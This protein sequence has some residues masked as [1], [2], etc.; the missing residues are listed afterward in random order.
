MAGARTD[1]RSFRLQLGLLFLFMALVLGAAIFGFMGYQQQQI[2]K[3][4]LKSQADV[5]A[6]LAAQDIARLVYLDEPDMASDIT[7]RLANIPEIH[8]AVFYDPRG[9][10]LLR[11]P[12]RGP[13]PRHAITLDVPVELNGMH[14]GHAR[15]TFF[16]PRLAAQQR[17]AQNLFFGFVGAVLLA[18]LLFA[19]YLDRAFVARLSRLSRAL[20]RA[21]SRGDFKQR[22]RPDR[23]DEIGQAQAHFDALL[24]LVETQTRELQ[25]QASHDGLTGLYNRNHLLQ[26]LERLLDVP[27]LKGFH[28]VCYLD[29]DRFKVVNDTC[30]HAAGDQLL[31]ELARLLLE[32]LRKEPGTLIGRLGGDE[33]LILVRDRPAQEIARLMNRVLRAIGHYE[34]RYLEREFPIGV[35]IGCILLREERGTP[36]EVISAADGACYQAK[37]QR[38][39]GIVTHRLDAPE[40]RAHQVRMDWVS[41]INTA[42]EARAFRLYLQPIVDAG[43]A[44][45]QLHYEALLRL[46]EAGQ[47]VIGPDQFIPVAERFGLSP[48]ID[49]WVMERLFEILYDNP[50]FLRRVGRIS[51]NLS[52]LT[53]ADP[54]NR[55]AIDRLFKAFPLAP[56]KLCFEIT[57]TAIISEM[58]QARRFMRHFRGRGVRFAMDDFGTGMASF[59]Y[60]KDLDF[61]ILKIDGSF[62]RPIVRDEVLRELTRAM[63]RIGRITGKE[64]V[65]EQVEDEPTAD[66]LRA[67]GVDYLQGWLFARARPIEAVIDE[68]CRSV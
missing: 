39:G 46:H 37:R 5:V 61:D 12:R 36:T 1:I 68:T 31:R 50:E 55:Q 6:K 23:D 16:S 59:A 49:L 45:A 25:Y 38:H 20:Q 22:L 3:A 51:V 17:H 43:A 54:H 28:A 21:A 13:V 53:V 14:L 41:R 62:V 47:G 56:Q 48:R 4:N 65:A 57:E 19:V 67:M 29:L 26:E 11:L 33:F 52:A 40:V 60:L 24:E 9:R 63:V 30:G 32:Q 7:A 27:P 64:I 35:S 66:L 44:S 10:L 18:G 42:L 8:S 2:L 58:A 15:L 34:F